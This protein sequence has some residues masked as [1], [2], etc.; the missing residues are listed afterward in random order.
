MWSTGK[1]FRAPQEGAS[2]SLPGS[3][4]FLTEAFLSVDSC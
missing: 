4:T 3:G 2:A 1:L